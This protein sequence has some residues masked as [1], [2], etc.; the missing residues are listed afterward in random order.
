MSKI[1]EQFERLQKIAALLLEVRQAVWF[2]YRP[3]LIS[4]TINAEKE[5][6]NNGTY[7]G[8]YLEYD[9]Y[10][11]TVDEVWYNDVNEIWIDEPYRTSRKEELLECIHTYV[12][13]QQCDSFTKDIPPMAL[14]LK[15]GDSITLINPNHTLEQIEA[16]VCGF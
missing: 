2:Y 11:K 5:W 10:Y 12:E 15:G 3:H 9:V 14:S 13:F 16:L 6:K 1:K 7:P 4:L 8:F